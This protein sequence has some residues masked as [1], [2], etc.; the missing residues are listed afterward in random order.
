MDKKT[1]ESLSI[2]EKVL[3]NIFTVI[4]VLGIF[5]ISCRA[6]MVEWGYIKE[7]LWNIINPFIH[8]RALLNLLYF[9]D[10]YVVILCWCIGFLLLKLFTNNKKND[11]LPKNKKKENT[12]KMNKKLVYAIIGI[13][14]ATFFINER[15]FTEPV[16]KNK[17][18]HKMVDTSEWWEQATPEL[19]ENL[20][21]KGVD[22]TTRDKAG[23]TSLM[24]AAMDSKNPGVIEILIKNGVD[25]NS[26]DM[27]GNTALLWASGFNENP[28]II[29][30]LIKYGANIKAKSQS[31]NDVLSMAAMSND[32]PAII[33]TLV[34]YGLDVKEKDKEGNT[35]LMWAASINENSD[36]IKTLIKHGIDIKS[37]NKEGKDA[38]MLAAQYNFNPM[39]IDI[40]IKYGADVRAKDILGKTALDYAKENPAIY[41]TNI[42]WQLNDLMYK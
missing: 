40:L 3:T 5:W 27:A 22:F 42:Y 41:N 10:I 6:I 18:E 16:F 29:H 38:L 2:K 1:K 36:I 15:Y 24:Y 21:K 25:V 28:D 14:L 19:I 39:I 33:E 35:L 37:K 17:T 11:A 9:P 8:F 34:S 20:I 4:G 13:I 30:V 31:N 12:T 26:R 7:S 23:R 32:N